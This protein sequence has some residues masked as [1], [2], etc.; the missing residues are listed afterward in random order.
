MVPRLGVESKLQL[1]A[2]TTA[3]AMPDQSHICET[4]AAA[5]SNAGSLT[6]QVRQGMEPASSQTLCQV[7]N[8]LRHKKVCFRKLTLGAAMEG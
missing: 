7:L 3:T 2:Y 1:L 8:P 5:C 4:Y 6:H